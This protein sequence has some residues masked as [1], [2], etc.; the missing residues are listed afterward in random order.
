MRVVSEQVRYRTREMQRV[1]AL[2]GRPLDE[3]LR[4]LY[5][6][7][8]LL[9]AEV[10]ARWGIGE[11]AVARWLQHFDIPARKGGPVREQVA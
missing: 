11:S 9:L 8:G 10:G 4:E 5:V 1:E 6:D 7:R 3:L 2:E